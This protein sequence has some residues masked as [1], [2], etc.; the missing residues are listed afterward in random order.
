[1]LTQDIAVFTALCRFAPD[2]AMPQRGWAHVIGAID[3]LFLFLDSLRTGNSG[4]VIAAGFNLRQETLDKEMLR[5][6]RL[7]AMPLTA[8]SLDAMASALF[9]GDE[10]FPDCGVVVDATGHHRGRRL[11]SSQTS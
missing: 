1:V 6:V 5:V 10:D 7:T 3:S 9:H 11:A 8:G 4:K 2:L